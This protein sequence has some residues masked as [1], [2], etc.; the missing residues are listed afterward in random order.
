MPS[1][2]LFWR[3]INRAFVL[4]EHGS[5]VGMRIG[6]VGMRIGRVGMRIGRV[7]MRIGRQSRAGFFRMPFDKMQSHTVPVEISKRNTKT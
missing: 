3:N 6:R 5:L 1:A 7:G 2:L 4:R